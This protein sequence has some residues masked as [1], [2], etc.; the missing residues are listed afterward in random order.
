M[1][2]VLNNNGQA[3]SNATVRRCAIAD[4]EAAAWA[5]RFA[6]ATRRECLPLTDYLQ[7]VEVP[8]LVNR[9]GKSALAPYT[10]RTQAQ[11]A[12]RTVMSGV[13]VFKTSKL[14][15]ILKPAP[16]RAILVYPICKW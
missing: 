6:S 13:G 3:I 11:P 15:K 14:T 16:L 10:S 4:R 5:R 1:T 12:K 2:A 9:A 8:F 7:T